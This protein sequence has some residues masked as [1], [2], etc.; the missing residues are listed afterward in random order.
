MSSEDIAAKLGLVLGLIVGAILMSFLFAFPIKWLW[1]EVMPYMF[2]LV[3]INWWQAWCLN[4]LSA[5][6]IKSS[7]LSFNKS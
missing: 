2:N 6:L 4:M 7:N 3:E 1:N 5:F